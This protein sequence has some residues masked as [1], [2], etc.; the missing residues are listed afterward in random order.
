MSCLFAGSHSRLMAPAVALFASKHRLSEWPRKEESLRLQGKAR[1]GSVA[2]DTPGSVR[3][4]IL[5]CHCIRAPELRLTEVEGE[6]LNGAGWR[7]K[8]FRSLSSPCHA[9]E[10]EQLEAR[11]AD[12]DF[13]SLA[14]VNICSRSSRKR[15]IQ[16]ANLIGT[17]VVALQLRFPYDHKHVRLGIL[18]YPGGGSAHPC[19]WGEHLAWRRG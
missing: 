1:P 2:P 18:L 4:A 8:S 3:R 16:T 19:V 7:E 10:G 6:T 13:L 11:P 9:N 14:L 15:G 17:S 12:S 5:R